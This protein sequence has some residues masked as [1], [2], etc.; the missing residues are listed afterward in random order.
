VGKYMVKLDF[1]ILNLSILSKCLGFSDLSK[2]TNWLN[3]YSKDGRV[4]MASGEKIRIVVDTLIDTE[5]DIDVC[6]DCRKFIE[7]VNYIRGF[8]KEG[9]CS[10][11]IK[12]DNLQI[13]N[14]TKNKIKNNLYL[15]YLSEEVSKIRAKNFNEI[16]VMTSKIM[17]TGVGFVATGADSSEKYSSQVPSVL[18]KTTKNELCLAG[19]D[20][21]K[22]CI[23]KLEI[24]S[25]KKSEVLISPNVARSVASIAALLDKDASVGY[26]ST[27]FKCSFGN[28]AV[29]SSK[30]NTDFPALDPLFEIT[31]PSITIEQNKFTSVLRGAMIASKGKQDNK[32]N[33]VIVGKLLR[34]HSTEFDVSLE[35]DAPIDGDNVDTALN[36][37][38]L[39]NMC[40]L[41]KEKYLNLQFNKP[42]VRISDGLG[43]KTAFLATLK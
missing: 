32:I 34:L 30:I 26:S 38:F 8:D 1:V 4:L 33:I 29:Y 20:S 12:D 6:V 18:I 39:Y 21:V 3:I 27:Y 40:S 17:K 35:L 41:F 37:I 7:Y 13:K 14:D 23:C 25:D 43:V 11:L 16:A 19:T 31:G 28:V 2:D 24:S 15:E 5:T 42:V 10:L 9:V 22:C 36:S